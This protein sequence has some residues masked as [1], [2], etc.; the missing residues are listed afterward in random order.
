M[1]IIDRFEGE[2]AVVEV[3][4]RMIDIPRSELPSGAK[5]GD[6]LQLVIRADDTL[7]RKKGIDVMM[8][9]LFKD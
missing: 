6:S 5:E 2:Y 9:S 7:S 3:S 4:G 1:L 8:N